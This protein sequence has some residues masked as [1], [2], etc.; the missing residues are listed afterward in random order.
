VNV[1]PSST[2][3]NKGGEVVGGGFAGHEIIVR[4]DR[5]AVAVNPGVEKTPVS[6]REVAS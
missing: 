4:R 3:V 5:A 2:H 1:T 6:S